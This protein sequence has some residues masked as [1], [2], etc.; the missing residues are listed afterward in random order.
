MIG[1][2]R[3]RRVAKGITNI[4]G[5]PKEVLRAPKFMFIKSIAQRMSWAAKRQATRAE[6]IAYSLLGIFDVQMPMQYGEGIRAFVRLQSEILNTTSDLSL[7]AWS[8][9]IKS[10]GSR[11]TQEKRVEH[12]RV[13]GGW[14]VSQYGLFA[15]HPK[16]FKDSR[17]I[18]SCGHYAS[19]TAVS[20]TN[21]ALYLELPLILEPGDTGSR[22]HYLAILPCVDNAFPERMVGIILRATKQPKCFVRVATI[23]GDFTCLV[24]ARLGVEAEV[25][26]I[27]IQRSHV[28]VHHH[29][30]QTGLDSQRT[31]AVESNAHADNFR[32]I[33]A[34]KL[35]LWDEE[36]MTLQLSRLDHPGM[37]FGLLLQ[38]SKRTRRIKICP[39]LVEHSDGTLGN[40]VVISELQQ[41]QELDWPWD[42]AGFNVSADAVLLLPDAKIRATAQSRRVFHHLITDLT[43]QVH[44]YKTTENP[45]DA[46]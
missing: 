13:F 4:T 39:Y 12:V 1:T 6:D 14:A 29:A 31:V 10:I 28:P 7:F 18:T 34:P 23:H 2:K 11:K 21:G 17:N 30:L 41:G 32:F 46:L 16:Y 36:D 45:D 9:S 38:H 22:L 19:S 42:F 5:I 26:N 37:L 25:T 44:H 24:K 35:H 43:I 27:C 15:A 8:Y 40:F 20:D 3:H 33:A